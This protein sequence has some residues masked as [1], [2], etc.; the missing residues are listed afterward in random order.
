MVPLEDEW[1]VRPIWPEDHGVLRELLAAVGF[2]LALERDRA[3]RRGHGWQVPAQT[4]LPLRRSAGSAYWRRWGYGLLGL[5][6]RGSSA[7]IADQRSWRARSAAMAAPVDL[8]HFAGSLPHRF[9]N[10]RNASGAC[11]SAST[12][13]CRCT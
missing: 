11:V 6:H 4:P 10:I 1:P 12:S 5:D 3:W 7:A 2:R 9:S 13:M 8:C